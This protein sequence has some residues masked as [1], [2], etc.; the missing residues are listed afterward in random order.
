[1]G[2]IFQVD[3]VE[4][5]GLSIAPSEQDGTQGYTVKNARFNTTTFIPAE[6][7]N[8]MDAGQVELASHQGRNVEHIVRVTG[9][10]A[11]VAGMNA[12]KRQEVKDRARTTI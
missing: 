7:F 11:K 3:R 5:T 6:K 1:M 4:P 9:Y 8:L 2:N 12:G 10:L